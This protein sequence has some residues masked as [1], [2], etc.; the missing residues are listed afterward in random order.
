MDY[1]NLRTRDFYDVHDHR[2]DLLARDKEVRLPWH[3]VGV[4][5]KGEVAR[6]VAHHFV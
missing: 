2:K 4:M 6:D 1:S 5:L 3:D